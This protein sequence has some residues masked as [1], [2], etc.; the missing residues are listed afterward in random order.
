MYGV[1]SMLLMIAYDIYLL[2]TIFSVQ[3]ITIGYVLMIMSLAPSAILMFYSKAQIW[4]KKFSLEYI[5]HP[6]M[7]QSLLTFA[8]CMSSV[9]S[10]ALSRSLYEWVILIPNMMFGF[11]VLIDDALVPYRKRK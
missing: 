1:S 8:L 6:R 7:I 5:R 10:K 9:Y 2:V 11:L 4:R 3:Q